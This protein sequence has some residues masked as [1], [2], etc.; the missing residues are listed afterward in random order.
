[1]AS[2]YPSAKSAMMKGQ[3]NLTG[4]SISIVLVKSSY[5]YSEAHT[6]VSASVSPHFAS[7][8]KVLVNN[9]VSTTG[10]FD[11]D[12]ITFPSVAAGSTVT[13]MLIFSGDIPVALIN[14]GL[15]FPVSTS[16]S[17]ISVVFSNGVDRI[18]R[19]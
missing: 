15:G 11:A 19:L 2:I 7:T 10:V 3:V 5:T 14:S 4:A 17:D 16:G 8:P 12:D 1:M 9:T 18:F 6:S 13:G